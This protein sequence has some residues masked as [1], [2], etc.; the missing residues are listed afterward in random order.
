MN[1]NTNRTT[2]TYCTCAISEL[3]NGGLRS[4]TPTCCRDCSG[5]IG[6]LV[7]DADKPPYWMA[8]TEQISDAEYRAHLKAAVLQTDIGEREWMTAAQ[9]ALLHVDL[10]DRQI[11]RPP[12]LY[13]IPLAD[14]VL[15]DERYIR[16][17]I[18]SEACI[19]P[20]RDKLIDLY[21]RILASE[22]AKDF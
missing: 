12:E 8:T 13:P 4:L 19:Y 10:K 5:S 3:T 20:E 21:F 11:W 14:D 6:D 1:I 22:I 9:D 2:R 7:T 18:K 16:Q 15:V 17:F